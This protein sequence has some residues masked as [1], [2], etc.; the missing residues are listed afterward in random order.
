MVVLPDESE[1]RRFL[2]L[3]QLTPP[4]A[5]ASVLRSENAE[6]NPHRA[7]AF[8]LYRSGDYKGAAE[9]FE[10][11]VRDDAEDALAA[12][13]LGVAWM[14]EQG[15]ERAIKA[16]A[17][18]AEAGHGLLQERALWYLAN[19]QLATEDARSARETLQRLIALEGD[20]LLNAVAKVREIDNLT[21]E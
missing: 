4:P 16:L 15:F 20:Y 1:Q 13:Y 19:A 7:Q 10:N 17:L 8:E 12:F 18:A 9:R 2:E 21:E 5:I 6:E 11:V 3:A 14:Q